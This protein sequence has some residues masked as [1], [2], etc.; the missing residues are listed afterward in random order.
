MG[1]GLE[2]EVVWGSGFLVFGRELG[3][4]KEK[5]RMG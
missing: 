5:W 4:R 3:L 1:R 2:G